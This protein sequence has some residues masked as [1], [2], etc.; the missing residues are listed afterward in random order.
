[1]ASIDENVSTVLLLRHLPTDREAYL[2]GKGCD[3]DEGSKDKQREF[4]FISEVVLAALENV[5]D[6]KKYESSLICTKLVLTL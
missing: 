1:L 4:Y 5:T 3:V 2:S 6:K